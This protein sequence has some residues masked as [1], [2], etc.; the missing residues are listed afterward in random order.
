MS[1]IDDNVRP[2]LLFTIP[3]G[4]FKDIMMHPRMQSLFELWNEN[5]VLDLLLGEPIIPFTTA[6][7]IMFMVGAV[8][9]TP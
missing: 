7:I 1:Q 8:N 6:I 4:P 2:L 3:A 5:V 9:H